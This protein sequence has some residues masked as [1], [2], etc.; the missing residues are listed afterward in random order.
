MPDYTTYG[1]GYVLDPVAV[2]PPWTPTGAVLPTKHVLPF[3]EPVHNQGHASNSP[4]LA[5]ASLKA[6]Q[7]FKEHRAYFD[8]DVDTW[9]LSVAGQTLSDAMSLLVSYGY[10]AKQEVYKLENA[11]PFPVATPAKLIDLT[12]IKEALLTGQPVLLGVEV[13]AGLTTPDALGVLPEPLGAAT[14][15]QAFVVYGWDD[16]KE[17]EVGTGALLLK[18][19]WGK[20][21]GVNGFV[22][23]GYNYLT[24][25]N[26]DAW[27]A[28]DS[29]DTLP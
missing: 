9:V 17:L 24:T 23:M 18:N 11:F 26:F 10:L 15:A 5:V 27:V 1:T 7:E 13:D 14:D 8:F 25:Y 3:R 4:A 12:E 28:S 6:Q 20:E 29:A 22:W 21:Y 2:Y 16:T 19:S